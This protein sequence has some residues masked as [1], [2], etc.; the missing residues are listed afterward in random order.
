MT[1]V[2][3]D[4]S[5]INY[6]VLIGEIHVLPQLFDRVIIPPAVI[7]ELQH[8]RAPK[9]VS[10]WAA[11]LP[12]W[13]EVRE[14]RTIDET[15]DLGPGE[16]AAISLAVEMGVDVILIDERKGSKAAEAR[17]LFPAGTL[18]VLNAA[19]ARGLLDFERAITNLLRTNF[20]VALPLIE[21]LRQKARARKSGQP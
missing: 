2:I 19:D 10:E 3:S 6:L 1:T 8:P 20:Q 18:N 12:N 4:T 15:L 17:G 13:V 9:V 7:R 16:T 21:Y 5:P 14:P 11:G